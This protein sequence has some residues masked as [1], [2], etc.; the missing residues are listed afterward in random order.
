MGATHF[1]MRRLA[2]VRTKMAL[3]VLAYKV[4]RM[5]AMLGVAGLRKAILA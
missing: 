2:N 1:Q 3:H 5:I 4:K